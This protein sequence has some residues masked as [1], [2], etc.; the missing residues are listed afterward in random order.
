[1]TLDGKLA[2]KT[3]DSKISSYND[4]VRLH[5][6]RSKVDAIIIGANTVKRDDPLLTVRYVKCNT[7][8]IRIVL[9]SKGTIKSNSRIIKTCSILPTIIAVS[10]KTSL[11][12][13]NRLSK[14]HLDIVSTGNIM[15]DIKQLLF[16]LKKKNINRILVE[17]GGIVNWN[18]IKQDLVDEIIVTISPYLVGGDDAVSLISGDGF[19]KIMNSKKLKLQNICRVGNEVTLYYVT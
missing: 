16:L 3:G 11:K 6:L 9:D 1:M 15:V 14:Y 4:K 5:K 12:N 8:P 18:F 13:L 2:T 7:N 17:G 10:K 19:R